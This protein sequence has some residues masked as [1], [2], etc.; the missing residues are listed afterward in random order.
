M[1]EGS[2]YMLF[3]RGSKEKQSFIEKGPCDG[4]G[5]SA[6]TDLYNL[7]YWKALD[8]ETLESK[9]VTGIG[10]P[11]YLVAAG[12]AKNACYQ[13]YQVP[14]VRKY[15]GEEFLHGVSAQYDDVRKEL[16]FVNLDDTDECMLFTKEL[17]LIIAKVL[18]PFLEKYDILAFYKG[19]SLQFI[20]R[21]ESKRMSHTHIEGRIL[22]I[23]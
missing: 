4:R 19:E 3:K 16:L 11:L 1:G 9:G 17:T 20:Y 22:W 8:C 12:F 21:N 18:E 2:S 10:K 15:Y 6:V 7:I 14:A 13:L 23:A 5:G